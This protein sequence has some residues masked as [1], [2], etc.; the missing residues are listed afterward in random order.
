MFRPGLGLLFLM[1]FLVFT[2]ISTICMALFNQIS[3][4]LMEKFI[5]WAS[6][7]I[8]RLFGLTLILFWE[9]KIKVR[10]NIENKACAIF[11][12]ADCTCQKLCFCYAFMLALDPEGHETSIWGLILST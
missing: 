2:M 4:C 9:M 3:Q 5:L 11:P 7:K 12:A 10:F 6:H 8:S 1:L